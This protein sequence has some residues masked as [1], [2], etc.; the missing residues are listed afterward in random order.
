LV[1]VS[2]DGKSQ[3]VTLTSPDAVMDV[4]NEKAKAKAPEKGKEKEK[5]FR[6]KAVYDKE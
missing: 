4:Y 2:A 3:D 5:G 1:V 6:N